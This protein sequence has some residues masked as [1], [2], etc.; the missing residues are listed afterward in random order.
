MFAIIVM[1]VTVDVCLSSFQ[2]P[3]LPCLQRW[4][5]YIFTMTVIT[6]I[7]SLSSLLPLVIVCNSS[8]YCGNCDDYNKN[9]SKTGNK[10]NKRTNSNK[11]TIVVLIA[12][13]ATK[14]ITAIKAITVII[15]I[16]VIMTVIVIIARIVFSIQK[17]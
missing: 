4:L 7:P 10:S 9:R 1:V 13:I 2:I 11:K 17:Q 16:K 8:D 5:L 14:A 12:I 6:I 3:I 15:A